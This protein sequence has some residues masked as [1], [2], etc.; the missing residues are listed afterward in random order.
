[1]K[2]TLNI[3][4]NEKN[5]TATTTRVIEEDITPEV[6]LNIVKQLEDGVQAREQDLKDLPIKIQ[7][8][9]EMAEAELKVLKERLKEFNKE[10][11]RLKSW[12]LINEKEQQRAHP[13]V[14]AAKHI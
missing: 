4:L 14:E 13:E 10:I 12:K 5:K 9:K 11:T 7:K 2:E 8:Q 1:M 3:K 6:Y